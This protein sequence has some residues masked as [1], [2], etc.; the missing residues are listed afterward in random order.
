[1]DGKKAIARILKAEGVDFVTCFPYNPI[2]DAVAAEG[3]FKIYRKR[4]NFRHIKQIIQSINNIR[5]ILF[6]SG[7]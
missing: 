2:I 4:D 6:F 5:N 3:K 7:L 1:M